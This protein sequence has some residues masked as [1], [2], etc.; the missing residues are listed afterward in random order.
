MSKNPEVCEA[1]V[2]LLHGHLVALVGQQAE[3]PLE[4]VVGE[5]DGEVVLLEPAGWFLHTVQA[6]VGKGEQLL[7]GENAELLERLKVT[8][9]KMADHYAA[10]EPADLAERWAKF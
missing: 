9:D 6:M 10:A 5:V 1:V 7:D 8:L 4:R 3:V 2:E